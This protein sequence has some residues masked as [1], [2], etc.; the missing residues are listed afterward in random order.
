MQAFSQQFIC[1]W[2]YQ[3][4]SFATHRNSSNAVL[5]V[6]LSSIL[7]LLHKHEQSWPGCPRIFTGHAHIISFGCPTFC[8]MVKKRKQIPGSHRRV[9][10]CNA[11]YTRTGN[12][13]EQNFLSGLWMQDSSLSFVHLRLHSASY[14]IQIVEPLYSIIDFHQF[15]SQLLIW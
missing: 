8:I 7:I 1:H 11:I 3:V 10:Q 4:K 9:L 6:F 12:Q 13:V 2:L 5:K 14:S 15:P